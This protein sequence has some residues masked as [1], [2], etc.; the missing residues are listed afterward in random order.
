TARDAGRTA[1]LHGARELAPS[2]R[3][4]VPGGASTR[5]ES[6]LPAEGLRHGLG[7]LNCDGGE[8]LRCGLSNGSG[9]AGARRYCI[10]ARALASGEPPDRRADER[11]AYGETMVQWQ[12]RYSAA[13]RGPDG[14]GL[15]AAWRKA[16]PY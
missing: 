10:G 12:G 2:H 15:Y 3:E 4:G 5:L 16:R 6:P 1:S 14:E 9:P 13:G 8:P 11:P 7:A